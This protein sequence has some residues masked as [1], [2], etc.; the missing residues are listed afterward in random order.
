MIGKGLVFGTLLLSSS[1]QAAALFGA[2]A[3]MEILYYQTDVSRKS[4]VDEVFFSVSG[5]VEN[6]KTSEKV[7]FRALFN[8][9]NRSK[10]GVEMGSLKKVFTI[11]DRVKYIHTNVSNWYSLQ[12]QHCPNNHHL[13]NTSELVFS[14]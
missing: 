7:P 6:R 11:G 12:S 2:G 4:A 9:G 10:I 5:Y 8:C 3:G 1:V 14:P 13:F